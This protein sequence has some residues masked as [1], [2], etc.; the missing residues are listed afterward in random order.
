[1]TECVDT[2]LMFSMHALSVV[3]CGFETQSSQIKQYKT[4]ICCFSTKHTS[5]LKWH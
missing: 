1:M 2:L 5:F 3:D 4:G